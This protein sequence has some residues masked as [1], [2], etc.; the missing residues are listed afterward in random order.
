[1]KKGS[2]PAAKATLILHFPVSRPVRNKFCPLLAKQLVDVL[3]YSRSCP[4]IN[5]E[6]IP[7]PLDPGLACDLLCPPE[8]GE[9]DAVPAPGL[10]FH[11]LATLTPYVEK[12]G[13]PL[14]QRGYS[15]GPCGGSLR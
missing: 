14:S 10:G 4:L 5:R 2:S 9:S 6:T 15:K 7:P 12:S 11:F 1:M 8:C 13:H 3:C